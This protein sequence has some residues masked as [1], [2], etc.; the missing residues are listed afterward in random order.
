MFNIAHYHFYFKDDAGERRVVLVGL[1]GAGKSDTGNSILLDENRAVFTSLPG[2]TSIT[3]DCKKGSRKD[4]TKNRTITV[5]DT[6]GMFDTNNNAT[7]IGRKI[8]ECVSSCLPGPHAILLVTPIDRVTPQTEQVMIDIVDLFGAG[9]LDYMIP[10]FTFGDLI[11]RN[12]KK[13]ITIE[14]VIK[15]APSELRRILRQ[16]NNRYVV[17]DNTL[18]AVSK[19][20][21]EQVQA[22]LD[23]VDQVISKNNGSYYTGSDLIKKANEENEL[24]R[25]REEEKFK[26][27]LDE[28]LKQKGKYYE[29][30]LNKANAR[31]TEA[32]A[33]H[34]EERKTQAAEIT[35]LKKKFNKQSMELEANR[36]KI[37]EQQRQLDKIMKEK[38]ELEENEIVELNEKID[39]QEQLIREAEEQAER[40]GLEKIR[41]ENALSDLNHTLAELKRQK[42]STEAEVKNL[43]ARENALKKELED[44]K[45]FYAQLQEVLQKDHGI[46]VKFDTTRSVA[47]VAR[48]MVP[49]SILTFLRGRNASDAG[50]DGSSCT[51]S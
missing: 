2:F 4:P 16:C 37:Q 17:F 43:N 1:T 36:V 18:D 21:K 15:G 35:R 50:R 44:T 11:T 12:R 28:K 23:V 10:A 48:E 9:S 41:K 42:T 46:K 20:N 26:K 45:A 24:V 33:R 49:K 27:K 6:P 51:I 47:T 5:V 39:M 34:L 32:N 40:S 22:F 29:E 31:L 19:E 25:K 3:G 7:I 38:R 30:Q 13:G 14:S 8:Y